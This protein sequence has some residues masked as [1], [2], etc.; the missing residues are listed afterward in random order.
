[1]GGAAFL[2]LFL[3]AA[4][5]GV[6]TGAVGESA[7]AKAAMAPG[8]FSGQL[9][10]EASVESQSRAGEAPLTP[11]ANPQLFAAELL[12]PRLALYLR[13]RDVAFSAWYAPRIFA[14]DP[15]PPG[16]S[17]TLILHTFGLNLGVL[18]SRDVTVTGSATGAIGEPD[19]T[20]LPLV[21]GTTQGAFPSTTI[22]ELA[23][24]TGQANVQARVTRRWDLTLAAQAFYWH[25]ID[26]TAMLAAPTTVGQVTGSAELGAMFRLTS[27]EAIGLSTA[28]GDASYWHDTSL[29]TVTPAAI[30]KA[31]LARR[32]EL[33]VTLGM[34]YARAFGMAP[35]GAMQPL[36]A[37]RSAVAP[38]GSVDLVARLTR[39]DDILFFGHL[40]SGVNFYLDPVLGT[41]DPRGYAG[42]ELGTVSVSGWTTGFRG[43]FGTTLRTTPYPIAPGQLPPDETAFSLALSV[44]R[45]V[46]EYLFAELGGRWADRGPALVTPDFQFHQRQLWIYLS[47]TGTTRPLPR[48]RL[49]VE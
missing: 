40:L 15:T 8:L 27:L 17:G 24:A 26:Q 11:D 30:W 43:D 41:A 49:P 2:A 12:I 47:L 37:A 21:L 3:L 46:S 39:R 36:G 5:P 14:E 48:A 10:V 18:P 42:L 9:E 35:A 45:R 16:T 44:R 23:S 29:V 19:Y 33:R 22:V 20:T 25:W 1:V 31:R 28:V 13:R 38:I 4:E 6:Q 32:E 7:V 34:A